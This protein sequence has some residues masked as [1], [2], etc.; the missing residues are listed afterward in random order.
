M[1]GQVPQVLRDITGATGLAIIRAMVAGARDPVKRARWR[2]RRCARRTEEIATAVTGHDRPAPVLALTHALALY[3]TSTAPLRGGDAESARH[4][5]ALKPVWPDARP[6]LTRADTRH[7]PSKH[8]PTD[9]ARRVRYQLTGV[10]V[11]AIPGVNAG[12]VHT[13]SSDVGTD[14]GQWPS[15]QAFC[16]WLTRAPS[17]EIS[18]GNM[19]RRGT[20]KPRHRAGQALRLAAQAV[21]RSHRGVG[22][23]SRRRRARLGPQSAS[24]A[25]AHTHARLVSHV[26]THRP[27][28]RDRSPEESE[29][30]ARARELATLRN[31]ATTLGLRRVESPA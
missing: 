30:R 17:H 5:A 6:P 9:E 1:H 3:D 12:T 15:E 21:R 18:G 24:V 11:G 25:T 7:S 28:F 8:A 13:L 19:L 22:A 29:P 23:C 26:R 4:V 10:D 14:R 27:P 20:R 16:A 2:D 31:K